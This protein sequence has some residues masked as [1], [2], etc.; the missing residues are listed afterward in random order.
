M[1]K[2]KFAR[3][4][5]GDIGF[6]GGIGFSGWLIRVGT[7][8][9]YGHCF[10]YH[11]DL[12]NGIWETAEAGPSGLLFRKRVVGPNKVVRLWRNEHEQQSILLASETLVGCKYGWGEI[13]RIACKFLGVKLKSRPD[14]KARVICSNH[15]AQSALAAR[16]DLAD[17][18]RYQSFEIWPGELAITF[19]VMHWNKEVLS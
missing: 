16:P 5:P 2:H 3:I 6:D 7:G 14:N 19:D 4:C 15:V 8:S 9:S 12:G 10:V 11:Q 18:M 13:F 17:Y 1:T